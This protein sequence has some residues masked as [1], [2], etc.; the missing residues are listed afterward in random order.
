MCQ[1]KGEPIVG[2]LAKFNPFLRLSDD[3]RI[4]LQLVSLIE[5]G[6]G[7]VHV[8]LPGKILYVNKPEDI[9]LIHEA[10]I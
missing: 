7:C 8:Y 6:E 3:R 9:T 2:E 5:V 1:C 4:N 10:T